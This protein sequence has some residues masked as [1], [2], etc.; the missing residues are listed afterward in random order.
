MSLFDRLGGMS[1]SWFRLPPPKALT[2]ST[3]IAKSAPNNQDQDSMEVI[4]S[5]TEEPNVLLF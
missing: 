1:S 2:S 5:E 4:L 3:I